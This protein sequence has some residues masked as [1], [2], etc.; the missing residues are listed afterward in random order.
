[1]M[2]PVASLGV[3]GDPFAVAA[4]PFAAQPPPPGVGAAVA[5][6]QYQ[7]PAAYAQGRQGMDQAFQAVREVDMGGVAGVPSGKPWLLPVVVGLVAL[8]VGGAITLV[9][10]MH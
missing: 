10:M 6:L 2:A 7:P 5:P 1:V 9:V 3:A 4:D 8:L